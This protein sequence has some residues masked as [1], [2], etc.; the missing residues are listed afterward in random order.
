MP[1]EDF[2]VT[3]KAEY[4]SFGGYAFGASAEGT[5][6]PEVLTGRV[7]VQS[8]R[9]GGQFDS[10]DGEKVGAQETKS[11]TGTLYF[12]PGDRLKMRA[13]VS[14]QHDEDW[15]NLI[16]NYSGNVPGCKIGAVAYFC[17]AIPHV[18][19]S[20]TTPSGQ[21][22]KITKALAN[23]DTSLIAPALVAAGRPN[24]LVDLLN[25]V[26]GVLNDVP[27]LG[28]V[29]LIDHFGSE[30]TVL[31]TSLVTDYDFGGGF[32]AAS[33]IG[34]G[35]FRSSS[36]RDNDSVLGY[37]ATRPNCA[38]T[39]SA[40]ARQACILQITQFLLVPFLARDFSADLRISSPRDKRVRVMLGVS[41]FKQ[42][43]DGNISGAGKSLSAGTGLA[44]AFINNDRDRS[45]AAGV[46]GSLSV[47][48]LRTLTLDLEAR[49]QKDAARQFTQT[50]SFA[51]GTIGYS[52][53]SYD[54]N[55]FLPRA[56]LNWKPNSSTTVYGS[57]AVGALAGIS[58]VSLNNLVA[59]IARNP[60][61]ALGTTDPAAIRTALAKLLG[62][63][64][65]IPDLVPAQKLKQI[66]LG[67]KQSFWGGKGSFTLAG[68][69]IDWSNIQTTAALLATQDLDGSGVL[70]PIN[71]ILP[72]KARIWG[73][74]AS[75]NLQPTS[76]VSM[77][78]QGEITDAKYTDYTIY[79][80]GAQVATN[81]SVLSGV[82]KTPLQYPTFSLF[83]MAR[84]TMPVSDEVSVYGQV[85]NNLVGKQYLDEANVAWIAPYDTVNLRTGFTYKEYSIEAYVTNLFDYSGPAGGRRNTLG[86]GTTGVTIFPA[87]LRTF[88]MRA[89][90][91]F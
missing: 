51:A 72:G 91:K 85:E 25:N 58:N 61:N 34:Y 27:I 8:F 84:Y 38:A 64:G 89:S 77:S 75:L 28:K 60:R 41:Y 81:G 12:T 4:K 1:T 37:T 49:Y 31:R 57:Y 24:A 13:R 78:L 40:T 11:V 79:G 26:N 52:P 46:F 44:T 3:G 62:Y 47:D 19:D 23:Q 55:K 82:G 69:H 30:D 36:L 45:Y 86:D 83:G 63:P 73:G 71:A 22:V 18:G 17:G 70:T 32:A 50:G 43:L 59:S 76:R 2:H 48:I 35:E 16:M 39:L 66:E 9:N 7:M 87:P 68:Y 80:V 42:W 14:Y 90:V 33:N 88:G 20:Y 54:F 56:I 67:W 21:V 29:P 53:L 15:G 10:G 74:E 6:L 5:L 65:T